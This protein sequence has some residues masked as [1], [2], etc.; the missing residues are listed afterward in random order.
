MRADLKN[1][2]A[3]TGPHGRS[4]TFSGGARFGIGRWGASLYGSGS[5]ISVGGVTSAAG[6]VGLLAFVGVLTAA[7]SCGIM[8]FV[9]I[10][11]SSLGFGGLSPENFDK[12]LGIGRSSKGS[13]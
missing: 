9:L 2:R 7:S 5:S 3:A 8:G 4:D 6:G 11:F 1:R 13:V 12:S 10:F